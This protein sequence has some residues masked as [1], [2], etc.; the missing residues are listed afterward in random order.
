MQVKALQE[1]LA[2]LI[3]RQE[4]AI[5]KEQADMLATQRKPIKDIWIDAGDMV[6][7]GLLGTNIKI[8][9]QRI[10]HNAATHMF[11]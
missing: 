9:V 3:T 6:A 1:E 2:G 8:N 10:S 4:A 7:H 11:I 5:A